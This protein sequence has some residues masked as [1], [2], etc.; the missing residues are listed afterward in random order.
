M[1]AAV[2]DDLPARADRDRGAADT[3]IDHAAERRPG[4]HVVGRV[5]GGVAVADDLSARTDRRGRAIG[6]PKRAKVDSAAVLRPR[7]RMTSVSG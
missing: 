3:K 2:A 7:K 1:T 4:E 6:P 5:V